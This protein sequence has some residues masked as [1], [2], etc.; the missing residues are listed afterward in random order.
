MERAA[1]E[2]R[3]DLSWGGNP[4]AATLSTN[5]RSES[6]T[7]TMHTRSE[8][9]KPILNLLQSDAKQSSITWM[10][11]NRYCN[12]NPQPFRLGA[13]SRDAL[14]QARRRREEPSPC[15]VPALRCCSVM[16]RVLA[17]T[18]RVAAAH[19]LLLG[20]AAMAQA[21]GRHLANKPITKSL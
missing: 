4:S 6:P 8:A 9:A 20:Q 16:L 12:G 11:C 1:P 7:K 19:S 5:A 13:V 18:S 3:R 17:P 10:A 2:G 14:S 21:L 15:A